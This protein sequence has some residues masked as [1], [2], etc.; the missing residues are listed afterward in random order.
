MGP[1]EATIALK[2]HIYNLN[3]FN[4]NL[5]ERTEHFAWSNSEDLSENTAQALSDLAT[6]TE[7]SVPSLE[8]AR[9]S[10]RSNTKHHT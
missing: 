8:R 7:T 5:P 10:K 4:D 1:C 9:G 2:S 3:Q 6:P